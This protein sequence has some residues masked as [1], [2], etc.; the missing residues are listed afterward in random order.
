MFVTDC[1]T[2][3]SELKADD[4]KAVLIREKAISPSPRF[5]LEALRTLGALCNAAEFDASTLKL[6]AQSMKI[7]GDATDQAI[8]RFSE[9]LETTQDLRQ[10]WKKVFEVGFNSKNK[11]MIRIMSSY[12]TKIASHVADPATGM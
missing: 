11:F 6:P 10:Q 7:F 1:L 4:A 9:A 12:D 2:G 3:G 5:A 8:L